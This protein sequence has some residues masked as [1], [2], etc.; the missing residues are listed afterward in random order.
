MIDTTNLLARLETYTNRL[1]FNYLPHVVKEDLGRAVVALKILQAEQSA[2]R[3]ALQDYNNPAVSLPVI[4][5]ILVTGVRQ[6]MEAKE[7]YRHDLELTERQRD[8]ALAQLAALNTHLCKMQVDMAKYLVPDNE[9]GTDW[10]VNRMIWHLDGPEQRKVQ[11]AGTSPVEPSP[12]DEK[13]YTITQTQVDFIVSCPQP[14]RVRT[15]FD[16][17]RPNTA[18]PSQ[19]RELSVWF[20]P[21]P[22]SNGK[23]NWTAILH[24]GDLA[25]GF[26]FGRSEYKDRVRYDADSMRHLIGELPNKPDILAYDGDLKEDCRIVKEPNHD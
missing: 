8:A 18:R 22:E 9:C 15:F 3:A 12:V 5:D 14:Y 6:E 17:L 26:Q 7:N 16:N 4:A 19:A 21:M 24:K 2:I 13:T 10:F 1:D 20:G 25:A 23:S 11:A